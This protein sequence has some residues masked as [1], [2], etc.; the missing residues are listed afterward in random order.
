LVVAILM[1]YIDKSGR[2]VPDPSPLSI[3]GLLAFFAAILAAIT[4]F[5]QTLFS[6]ETTNKVIEQGKSRGFG[7]RDD[8]KRPMGGVGKGGASNCRLP[9]G[10]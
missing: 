1:V 3:Q 4:L 2:V 7:E 10:G 9:G 6:Q 8:Y 5:F